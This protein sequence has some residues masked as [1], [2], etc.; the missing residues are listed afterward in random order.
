VPI[1]FAASKML[2]N[3]CFG[4]KHASFRRNPIVDRPA[5]GFFKSPPK[6]AIIVAAHNFMKPSPFWRLVVRLPALKT[7]APIAR[8]SFRR[9]ANNDGREPPLAQRPMRQNQQSNP[10]QPLK[11]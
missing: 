10:Y 11:R 2:K 6:A 3:S 9:C 8:G 7:L 5:G 4:V 1:E